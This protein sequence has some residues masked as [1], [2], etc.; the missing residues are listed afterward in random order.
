MSQLQG[1]EIK[2]NIFSSK[3]NQVTPPK[4]KPPEFA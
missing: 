2:A 1:E 3:K 4:L